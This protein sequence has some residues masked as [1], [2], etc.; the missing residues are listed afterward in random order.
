MRL[1]RTLGAFLLVVSAAVVLAAL[2]GALH[3]QLTYTIS[4]ENFTRFKFVQF[5]Y[6]GVGDMPPRLGAALVGALATWTVGLAAGVLVGAAGV[7]HRDPRT[8]VRATMRA[9]GVVA[10]AAA[11][12][13]LL[14]LVL[15]LAAFGSDEQAARIA[16]W[17][18]DGVMSPRRFHAVGVMHTWGYHGGAIGI[19]AA[20]ILQLRGAVVHAPVTGG[21]DA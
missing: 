5:A 6:A 12:A 20:M 19:V 14:G 15:L 4:P 11:A 7:A 17:R 1:I 21:T 18:P 8:R 16:W 13:G 3:N 10:A 9:F 2:Y